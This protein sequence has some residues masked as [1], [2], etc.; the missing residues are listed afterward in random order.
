MRYSTDKWSVNWW[1]LKKMKCWCR[2]QSQR[3]PNPEFVAVLVILSHLILNAECILVEGY[4][5]SEGYRIRF[6]VGWEAWRDSVEH[7]VGL[8]RRGMC[9]F[10]F[11]SSVVTYSLLCNVALDYSDQVFVSYVRVDMLH[12]VPSP[13]IIP[14][15]DKK[16]II[17]DSDKK[18]QG[19][20]WGSDDPGG[21]GAKVMC[22]KFSLSG[23][24]RW[25]P[26]GHGSSASKVKGRFRGKIGAQVW[27]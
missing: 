9:S 3:K 15:S 14:D 12:F 24:H 16:V 11:L 20:K 19:L 5:P 6:T 27:S 25:V 23:C 10:W 17:P 22:S 26:H 13:V 8:H 1:R 2:Q 21:N 7:I 18:V 4:H